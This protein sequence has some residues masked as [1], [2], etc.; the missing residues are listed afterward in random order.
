[1][2]C[3]NTDE[4]RLLLS[5]DALENQQAVKVKATPL[6]LV[7]LGGKHHLFRR[8][9]YQLSIIEAELGFPK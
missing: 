7:Q 8:H 6:P 3:A 5:D 1:M 9:T 4:T 2:T